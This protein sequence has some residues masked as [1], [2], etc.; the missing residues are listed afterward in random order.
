M[1][2]EDE[3]PIQ[4]IGPPKPWRFRAALSPRKTYSAESRIKY[5]RRKHLW[6]ENDAERILNYVTDKSPIADMPFIWKILNWIA[7]YM[8]EK[9]F[10][11]VS[12]SEEA[13]WVFWTGLNSWWQG[14][15]L[16]AFKGDTFL[17][18]TQRAFQERYDQALKK[19]IRSGDG[20]LLQ[21]LWNDLFGIKEE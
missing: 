16:K 9:L 18:Q 21:A 5:K 8:G 10:A 7:N 1:A 13:W 6:T 14:L 11:A 4:E 19:Y 20:E 17:M 2:Q 15:L 12:L 3:F